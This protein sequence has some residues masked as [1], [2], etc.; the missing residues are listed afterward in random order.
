MSLFS[1]NTRDT[2]DSGW[3][4]HYDEAGNVI[5]ITDK[6]GGLIKHFEQ[7]AWGNDLNGSFSTTQNI[8]Q[9]QTGKYLDE[10]TGLYFFGARW[11]DPNIGRFISVSPLSP[12]GEEEYVY[13]SENPV[14]SFDVKGL[15]IFSTVD[16]YWKR[17]EDIDPELIIRGFSSNDVANLDISLAT[18]G[19]VTQ[20]IAC[21]LAKTSTEQFLFG[22]ATGGLS[23]PIAGIY[24]A[25]HTISTFKKFKNVYGA[26]RK[27][28][29]WHHIVEQRMVGKF[30][31]EIIHSKANLIQVKREVHDLIG[32]YYSSKQEFSNGMIIRKWLENK[33]FSEQFSFG[34]RILRKHGAI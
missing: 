11:Y 13:C 20:E 21:E 27:G 9:H 1:G 26:A 22:L 23:T 15:S 17:Y 19:Q 5:L 3:F 34:L 24:N 8:R 7:D 18:T 32:A 31:G 28:Y 14:N 10:A 12:L 25:V 4:Y 2:S 16:E 29:V 33:S 6:N 30:G